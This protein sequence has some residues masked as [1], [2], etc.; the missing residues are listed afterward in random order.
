MGNENNLISRNCKQKLKQ[1]N[2]TPWHKERNQSNSPKSSL[3]KSGRH[4]PTI[5]Q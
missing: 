5:T 2:S 3:A 4:F 1:S